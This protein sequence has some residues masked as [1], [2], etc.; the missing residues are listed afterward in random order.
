[1]NNEPRYGL[2]L[3]DGQLERRA[4]QL[5]VHGRR[6]RPARALAGVQVQHHGQVQPAAARADVGEFSRINRRTR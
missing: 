1:M 2:A 3:R 5:G 6:H 4:H